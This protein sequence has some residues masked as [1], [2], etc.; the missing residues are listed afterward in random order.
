MGKVLVVA[1][2]G[3]DY[4]L[5]QEYGLENVKQQEFG[6]IDNS[7]GVSSIVTDELFASFI[8]GKTW[9]EHGVR[10]LNRIESPVL[11]RI[12][13][14]NRYG[15]F[16]KFRS[17]RERIYE[18]LPFVKGDTRGYT[19]KD[20]ESETLFDIIENS[21]AIDVPSYN[22]GYSYQ[23]LRHLDHGLDKVSEELDRFTK[24]KK[25]ELFEAMEED[26]DFLM[27]HFHKP[28]HIHHWFWEID[29]MEKVEKTYE[30]IDELA[31]EI[32]QKAEGEF[33]TIIF[34][35]DHGLPEVEEGGHNEKAFYS[36]NH[37][38]FPDS[39]PHITDFFD[40]ILE[41]IDSGEKDLGGVEV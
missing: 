3:L 8:T 12:E 2:D 1:F 14:L 16:Q 11:K 27:A 39:T 33:D 32:I 7:T 17:I 41:E 9:E 4:D 20:I 15:F 38:L 37:E 13:D 28:D 36:C 10:G 24:W 21:E 35:S 18:I 26:H 40:R 34:F 31:G 23:I 5:I 30:E 22:I 6:T 19:K 25:W 29:R